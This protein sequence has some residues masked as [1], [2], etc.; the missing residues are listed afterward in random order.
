M[1]DSRSL[2]ATSLD[3]GRSFLGRNQ[4]QQLGPIRRLFLAEVSPHFSGQGQGC[5]PLLECCIDNHLRRQQSSEQPPDFAP[6]LAD[7]S[8]VFR[9]IEMEGSPQTKTERD[10]AA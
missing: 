9:N 10:D 4:R 7:S 3:N 8:G 1:F 2:G 5:P 6:S